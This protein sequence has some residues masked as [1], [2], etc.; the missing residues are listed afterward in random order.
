MLGLLLR[1]GD[2][3]IVEVQVLLLKHS[4]AVLKRVVFGC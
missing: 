4:G 1:H 2:A 3:S